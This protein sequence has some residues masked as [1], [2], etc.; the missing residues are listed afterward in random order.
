MVNNVQGEKG[1]VFLNFVREN[2]RRIQEDRA[3]MLQPYDCQPGLRGRMGFKGVVQVVG[4][5]LKATLRHLGSIAGR[6]F[7]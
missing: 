3:D 6:M 5:H 2:L 7:G 4:G 1:D